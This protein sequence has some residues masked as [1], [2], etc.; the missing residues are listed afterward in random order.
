MPSLGIVL[1]G[2]SRGD[3]VGRFISSSRSLRRVGGA[4]RGEG[5]ADVFERV[6]AARD[7]Q[8]GG[9]LAQLESIG[10]IHVEGNNPAGVDRL[11][12]VLVARGCRQSLQELR[13]GFAVGYD[14]SRRNMPV[15]LALDRLIRRCCRPDAPLTLTT[16][17]GRFGFDL[18]VFYHHEF[19]IRP[20]PPLKTMIQQL[21]LQAASVR[22][23][24]TGDGLT[25][26]HASHSQ[27][28]SEMAKTL[29]FDEATKVLAHNDAP[30]LDP[31]ANTPSPDPAMISHLQPFPKASELH[32]WSNLGV[33]AGQLFASKMPKK[34]GRVDIYRLSG[35]E[36]KVGVLAA[37]GRE[38]E[39]SE[40]RMGEVGVDQLVGAD[41]LPTI[42]ALDFK[43]TLPTGV[44]DAGSVVRTG[45]VS[46]IRHIRGLQRVTLTVDA[47]AVQ[48]DSIRA[49]F[50][51]GTNV[52]GLTININR[53]F[54]GTYVKMTA[55]SNA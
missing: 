14:I 23:T 27:S 19:P 21:A 49:P 15:L 55:P 40:V 48:H 13:V 42:K 20:S 16:T 33:A 53:V 30:G 37:L 8:Q 51:V 10:T 3:R 36:E 9:R 29:S 31:P 11:Q 7:G 35:A 22:Y 47:T 26:P 45:L 39:V 43:L 17:C 2:G 52:G 28:A 44:E 4:F 25:D 54:G 18:S 46:V 1:E 38:R 41:R 50:P 24:F 12:E 34:V 5:W 6:P 32:V